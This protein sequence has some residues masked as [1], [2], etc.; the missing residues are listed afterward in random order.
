MQDGNEA[1]DESGNAETETGVN[2][3]SSQ[4]QV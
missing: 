2:E 4:A 3:T 1:S